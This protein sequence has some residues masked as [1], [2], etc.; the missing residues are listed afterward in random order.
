MGAEILE[1][2]GIFEVYDT[3]A[4]VGIRDNALGNYRSPYTT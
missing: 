3:K 4:V 2:S 1:N